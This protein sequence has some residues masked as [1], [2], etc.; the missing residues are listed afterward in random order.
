VFTSTHSRCLLAL[1]LVPIAFFFWLKLNNQW[2]PEAKEAVLFEAV[3]YR[4]SIGLATYEDAIPYSV[5]LYA[6]ETPEKSLKPISASLLRRL[7]AA[8]PAKKWTTVESAAS[9]FAHSR[10]CHIKLLPQY[11]PFSKARVQIT[12]TVE[13]GQLSAAMG[14][15]VFVS[16]SP[17]L[18]GSRPWTVKAP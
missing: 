1:P 8:F 6:P 14:S 5:A 4:M 9:G 17:I 11:H 2:T 12:D 15:V 10:G 7:E 3:E 18:A 16:R 13:T